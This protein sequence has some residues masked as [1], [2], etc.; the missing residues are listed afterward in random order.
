MN[1]NHILKRI[2]HLAKYFTHN[3]LW[4][5]LYSRN[6][7]TKRESIKCNREKIMLKSD[8]TDVMIHVCDRLYYPDYS[9]VM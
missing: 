5:H 4:R 7:T 6:I 3:M 8:T 1:T 9:Q 2:N